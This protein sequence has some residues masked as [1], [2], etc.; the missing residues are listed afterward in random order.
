[1]A[2]NSSNSTEELPRV[3]PSLDGDDG[4]AA[5]ADGKR[6]DDSPLEARKHRHAPTPGF[7]EL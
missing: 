5:A 1:M 7:K 6:E 4:A 3:R 2:N